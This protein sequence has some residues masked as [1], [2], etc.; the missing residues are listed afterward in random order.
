MDELHRHRSFPDA[1]SYSLYG[2]MAHVAHGKNAGNVRLKQEGIP[3]EGPSLR[4]LP[5]TDKVR[6][7]QEET[8]LVTL[9]D[10]G[11]PIRP[12]QRANKD[13]HRSRGHA[14]DLIGV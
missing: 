11:Q 13:K 12:W 4:A 2:A 8:A 10:I 1:G 5:V 7:G 9:D 3:V 14:L 6:A